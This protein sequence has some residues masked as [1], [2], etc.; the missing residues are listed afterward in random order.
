K[1]NDIFITTKKDE[2]NHGFGLNSVQ[3]AIKKY[4]GLLD[5]TYDEKLFL[6]NILLYTDNIMQ[7]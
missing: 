7:I 5:I 3:N 4:N 2:N 6:V 1:E